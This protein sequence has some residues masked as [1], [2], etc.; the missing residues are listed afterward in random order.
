MFTQN[1]G[2][3]QGDDESQCERCHGTGIVVVSVLV[4]SI[5]LHSIEA[6]V[7]CSCDEGNAIFDRLN[8][9]LE[10]GIDESTKES[11]R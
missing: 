6:S 3:T 9:L 10:K 8:N 5:G 11:K 4:G 1:S 7:A 2:A